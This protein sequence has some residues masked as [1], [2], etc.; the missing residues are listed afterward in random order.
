MSCSAYGRRH[1]EKQQ[2]SILSE[3]CK[4]PALLP[5]AASEFFWQQAVS[6]RSIKIRCYNSG[7]G[8]SDWHVLY[9]D[10]IKNIHLS[11]FRNLKFVFSVL[12][13]SSSIS[14]L[15][16]SI[17]VRTAPPVSVRVRV[18]VSVRP[19]FSFTVLCLQRWRYIFLMCSLYLK[20]IN[21]AYKNKAKIKKLV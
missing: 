18:R 10:S 7:S 4:N 17:R 19:S 14:L 15:Y 21:C 11:Y 8:C 1:L 20:N 12:I 5:A 9:L 3:R 6:R 2:V 16:P 13:C